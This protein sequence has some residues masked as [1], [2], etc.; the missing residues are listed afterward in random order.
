MTITV[1]F[2]VSCWCCG[3]QD[4]DEAVR[5]YVETIYR[6]DNRDTF[7]EANIAAFGRIIP[8]RLSTYYASKRG[9]KGIVCTMSEVAPLIDEAMITYFGSNSGSNQ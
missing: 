5:D 4:I 2:N 1:T 9:G 8:I 6:H 3:Y 7:L